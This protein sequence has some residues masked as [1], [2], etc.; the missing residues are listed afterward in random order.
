MELAELLGELS[1]AQQ[2]LLDLLTAKRQRMV[3]SD[4]AGMAELQTREQRLCDRL[5]ACHNRRS[6]LLGTAAQQ[7]LPSEN[8]GK[9]AGSLKT[10]KGGV[11]HKQVKDASAQMRALQ[12]QSLTNWVLAQR[13]MLHLSQLLE[14]VATGGRLQ[15]TY[16]RGEVSTSSGALVDSE[17]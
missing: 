4:L 9:L 11:L 7:G 8:L 12:L 16:G 2:E 3:E 1:N 6:E 13:A 5:Q 15:P 10:E 17:A 14:I